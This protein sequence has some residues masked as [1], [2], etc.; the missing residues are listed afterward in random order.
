[1]VVAGGDGTIGF[2]VRKLADSKRPV[3]IISLGRFNN[4]AAA[5]G[6]PESLAGAIRVVKS[7]QPRPITLG[8]VNGRV[9]LEACAIGLFGTTIMLGES[10][11]E[12]KF[13]TLARELRQFVAAK[14]FKYELDEDIKGSGTARSLVF[15]NTGSIG[16]RLPV[17]ETSPIEQY[18]EFSVHA[19]A[20]RTDIVGRAL[21]SAVLMKHKEDTGQV[22]RFKKLTVTTKPKVRVYAD[23]KLVGRTPASVTAAQSALRVILPQGADNK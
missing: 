16:S 3:G 5:L 7:G 4:F 11:K 13:G 19:G 12:R 20:T 21:A 9:F 8:R 6:L 2:V 17:S 14:P 23:N 10:A 18:L 15:S 22:F 1:V